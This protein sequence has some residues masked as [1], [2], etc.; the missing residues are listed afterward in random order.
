MAYVPYDLPGEFYRHKEVRE[1]TDKLRDQHQ[2]EHGPCSGNYR[3]HARE[4]AEIFRKC[5]GWK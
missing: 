3:D 2:A 1:L 4:A 5:R